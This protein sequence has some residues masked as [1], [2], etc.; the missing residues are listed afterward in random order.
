MK[1]IRL[2]LLILGFCFL[3][4]AKAQYFVLFTDSK[5]G[6][7]QADVAVHMSLLKPGKSPEYGF[8][9]TDQKGMVQVKD[10]GDYLIQVATPGFKVFQDTLH[11]NHQ[12][13]KPLTIIL[14]T[15]DFDLNEV[16]VTGE[17]EINT[18][19]RSI[20]RVR[21]IDRKRIERQGAVNLRDLL[22]NELNIRLNVDP[23]LGTSLSLQGLSGQNIKILIDGVPLIGRTDG[24]IDLSQINLANIERIEIIEGPM[25][26]MY[27]TDALGGVINLITKKSSSHTFEFGQNSYYES[28]GTYNFD[29][30]LGWRKKGWNMQVSGGRN[31]FEGV[32]IGDE[33]RN[34]T[35]KPREQKYADLMFG[36]K[37][38]NSLHRLQSSYFKEKITSRGEAVFT[39]YAIYGRDQY[40]ITTR[41]N[42]ALFSDFRINPNT[43]LNLINSY[44]YFSREKQTFRKDLVS[45]EQVRTGDSEDQDTAKFSLILFRGILS[46]RI[47]KRLHIQTGYDIN[48]EKAIGERIKDQTQSIQDYAVFAAGEWMPFSRMTV[49]PGVRFIYN[50][51]Y[52]APV[53][54]S[55]NLKYDL[56]SKL[57]LRASYARGFRAPSLKELSFLFVDVNHNVQ[58]NTDLKAETSNNF[59]I[60]LAN[61]VNFKKWSYKLELAAYHNQIYDMINL[62]LTNAQ[63]NL[64]QYVNIDQ[65]RTQ[66]FNINGEF[67][68]SGISLSTGYALIGRYNSLS[69]SSYVYSPEYKANI[70]YTIPGIHTDFSLFYKV[71]GAT[72]GFALNANN[73]VIQTKINGYQT[74]DMSL[75]QS[76]FKR[77]LTF[78][79]GV[80]NVFDV[81]NINYSGAGTGGAHSGGGSTLPVNMGRTW[82]MNLRINLIR[83]K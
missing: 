1:N 32:A 37:I 24:N 33:L 38:K 5:E 56:N 72:P 62:V 40:F 29:G 67:K 77:R 12:R 79:L 60:S 26:V 41:I 23:I 22:S 17:F 76:L 39:P 4:G 78:V 48:L 13:P 66:G 11:V 83:M 34:K 27:G 70:V 51:R 58:G 21:T 82:F 9:L 46:H 7:A 59:N 80:K 30:R 25:S 14:E 65:F 44:S 57:A 8:Y 18:V 61:Q 52:G 35:W 6:R 53:V 81:T 15:L 31:F 64:Y 63:T 16:V 71:T 73:E 28:N 43:T 47:N 10:S 49:K 3:E 2:I 54:P 69:S 36:K 50:T 45:L 20:N 42:N 68:R 55:L 74:M 19:D 75:T